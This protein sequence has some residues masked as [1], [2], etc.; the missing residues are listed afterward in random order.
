MDA[1]VTLTPSQALLSQAKE[2]ARRGQR[3]EARSR[4]ERLL[5][6][7]PDHFDALLWLAALAQDPQES[8]RYLRRALVVS[9]DSPAALAGLRWA[10]ERA[11]GS[12]PS[13]DTSAVAGESSLPLLVDVLLLSGVVVVAVAA[14]IILV[15]M[16]FQGPETIRAA[17]APTATATLTLVPTPT[18]PPTVSA[19]TLP[20]STPTP[21]PKATH[22]PLPTDTATRVGSAQPSLR[23]SLGIK[24]I[25][26]DLSEQQLTA[27]EGEAV[28][29]Q[30]LVSTGIARYPTPLGEYQVIRKVPKQVMSGPDYYLPNVEFVSY[31]Y[32]GYAMHGTYWHDNFGQPMSHGCVNMRNDDAQWVYA[33]APQG[34]PVTVRR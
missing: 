34:T 15:F 26:I 10:E 11:R 9:P 2:L 12:Q 30:V 1:R 20:T 22:T 18:F 7:E 8:I 6:A 32:K 29:L 33:W 27:Y 21:Q 13:R 14:C 25:E 3:R 16:L 24:R 4:L 19:T 23:T 17:Y 28:V 5:G 31:F